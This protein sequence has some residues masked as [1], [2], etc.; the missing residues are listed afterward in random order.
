MWL[1]SSRVTGSM[2]WNSSSIPIVNF[3]AMGLTARIV[4]ACTRRAR[5]A[6]ACGRGRRAALAALAVLSCAAPAAPGE[7]GS[8]PRGPIELRDE[9]LLCQMRLTLPALAPDPL[10]SGR[11]RLRL[12]FDWGNDF[13]CSQDVRGE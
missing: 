4:P 3:S 11:S 7:G 12:A 13:G 6:R 8:A 9:W 10:P 5:G 2:S 1:L